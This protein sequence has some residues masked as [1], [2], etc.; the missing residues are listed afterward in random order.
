M[1]NQDIQRSIAGIPFD[2]K[3]CN[4]KRRAQNRDGGDVLN[5]QHDKNV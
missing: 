3:T 5:R 2:N 1:V 4:R